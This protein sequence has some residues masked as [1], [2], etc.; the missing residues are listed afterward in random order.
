MADLENLKTRTALDP[1]EIIIGGPSDAGVVLTEIPFRTKLVL[2]G[3]LSEKAFV[4]AVK[5]VLGAAPPPEP[6][7]VASAKDVRILWTGPDEWMVYGDDAALAGKLSKALEGQHAAVT[8]V[9]E[10]HTTIRLSG[11]HARDVMAKGCAIDLHPRAFGPGKCAQSHIGR[12]TVLFDQL[13]EVPTYDILVR[14][15]FAEYLWSYLEDA[16]L[17]FGVRIESLG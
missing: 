10:H 11:R 14:S 12:I 6:N 9:T 8:E 13:D 17:E 15:S 5:S 3:H 7:T 16:G 4:T 2:R 1:L